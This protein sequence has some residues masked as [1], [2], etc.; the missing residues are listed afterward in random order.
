MLQFR[1]PTLETLRAFVQQQRALD[2]TYPAVG[3]TATAPPTDFTIDRTRVPLG[4]GPEVF[5]AAKLALRNWKQF[6]LGWVEAW[7]A[8]TPIEIGHAVA[9]VAR[10]GF[11]WW[12]NACRIVYTVNEPR[13]FGFAYGTLPMHVESGEERF[14][15]EMDDAGAVWFD[16]LA[17]SKP[18][19]FLARLAYP[20]MR[21][22]QKR[23]A[24]HSTAALQRTVNA[25]E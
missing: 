25:V 22:L 19:H 14:L 6:D 24:R 18:A 21:R 7:R 23:F 10:F 15:V 20:I 8:D 11:V 5:A 16:I 1:K 12:L 9:V 13:R 3:A 2:F 4:V 17:F